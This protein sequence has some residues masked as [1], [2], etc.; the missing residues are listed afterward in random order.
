V[1]NPSPEK[2]VSGE[3]VVD[4]VNFMLSVEL[5]PDEY[6]DGDDISVAEDAHIVGESISLSSSDVTLA[7]IDMGMV[8]EAYELEVVLARKNEEE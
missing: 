7:G 6:T 1:R 8:T 2:T 4:L 5:L 3:G